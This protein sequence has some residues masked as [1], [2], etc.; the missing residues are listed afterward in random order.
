[1]SRTINEIQQ[2][3]LDAKDASSEL[4]TLEVLTDSEQSDLS[5][6]LTSTSKVSIW[7]LFVWVVA[8][9]IWVHEQLMDVL[10]NDIE[11]RIAETRPFTRNWYIATSLKYQHGYD[12][13][14]TGVYPD[15][16]NAAET[17]AVNASKI[18]KKAAVVQQIISG[19]GALRIKVATL[20]AGELEPVTTA[21]LAGFQE[22][23][24]LM[25]AAGVF[26]I[27]TTSEA[28]DLKLEIDVHF[29]PLIIDNEGK[30]LDGTN[31]TP[32][33]TAVKDYLKSVEFNGVL[34][35]VKLS[36]IIEAVEGVESPFI[37]L[38]ASKYAA[39]EYDTTGIE[40]AGAFTKFRQPD[41][42][43][44]K[45]DEAESTFNFITT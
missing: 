16:T 26:V 39:F 19:V 10:K 22:Y 38:A 33:Q 13:P 34:D 40:N 9:A 35:L 2:T 7:R 31:D 23:I 42:G 18:I 36:N 37:T 6:T 3:I 4:D 28:D 27:A 15:P 44:F 25:G 21:Q 17:A 14:E 29:N 32:V 5:G 8:F 24:E 41:S 30:R 43:Y 12:L 11:K 45:L 20:T 1:M